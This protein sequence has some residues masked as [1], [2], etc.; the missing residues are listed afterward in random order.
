MN[1]LYYKNV[2]PL[3]KEDEVKALFS[4]FGD[5]KSFIM[6]EN[7]YGKFGFVCYEDKTG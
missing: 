5:I 7:E 6:K 4:G 2:P 3:M 1:N